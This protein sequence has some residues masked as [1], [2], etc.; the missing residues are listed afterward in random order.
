MS[1]YFAY[2]FW[3][4]LLVFFD[5]NFNGFDVLPDGIG[6]ALIGFGAAGLATR[7]PHFLTASSLCWLLVVAWVIEFFVS[8]V[9]GRM[10]GVLAT[11]LNL[12]MHWTLLGG[13]I[14]VAVAHTR[15][16]LAT[17]AAHRRLAYVV[18]GVLS[19]TV[20]LLFEGSHSLLLVLLVVV[21]AIVVAIMIMHLIYRVGHELKT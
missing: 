8:G 2:I 15:P 7:S 17:R 18:I 16:D 12:A 1:V 4:L 14:D 13:V 9:A 21:P 6:F 3:G 5:F 11:L 10:F 20:S 19:L